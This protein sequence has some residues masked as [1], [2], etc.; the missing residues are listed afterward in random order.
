MRI[1][2][3]LLTGTLAAV[4]VAALAPSAGAD[5]GGGANT[6]AVTINDSGPASPSPSTITLSD[7]SGVVT[8]VAVTLDSVS[9]TWPDDLEIVL[10]APSGETVMLLNDCGGGADID[11]IDLRFAS[12]GETPPDGSSLIETTYAPFSCA[13]SGSIVI[14]TPAGPYGADFSVFDGIDPNG[15]WDLYIYDDV[16][17][18]TGDLAGWSIEVETT[19][20][21]PV[22]S[23]GGYTATE[24]LPLSVSAGLGLASTTVDPDDLDVLTWSATQPANG[25]VVL[26]SSDGSFTYTPD[27]DFTGV[28]TFTYSA[29]D[30]VPGIIILPAADRFYVASGG[31]EPAAEDKTDDGQSTGAPAATVE[32]PRPAS[33]SGAVRAAESNTSTITITVQP[34]NDPPTAVDDTAETTSGTAV[35][36][37]AAANDTD[38][39]DDTLTV[40]GVSDGVNG[41]ATVTDGDVVYTPDDDFVGT[42]VLTYTVSDGNGGEDEGEITIEVS[43]EEVD[44]TTTTT[45]ATTPTTTAASPTGTLPRTGAN[46]GP[47]GTLATTAYLLLAA[48]FL[49]TV[50]GGMWA[51]TRYQ[52]RHLRDA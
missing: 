33:K 11:A 7:I 38:V 4:S 49:L 45:T 21:A 1:G 34:V 47:T 28:D 9:H 17:A 48:G 35:T 10:E 3:I 40:T 46:G 44:D 14:P 5:A 36:V 27:P 42:E 15:A 13:F 41:T 39:E 32:I 16:G 12:G 26:D 25:T 43:A 18:D 51:R 37:D 31:A 19:N 8:D 23:D 29:D 24:D 6:G 20:T 2:R 30:G 52:P 50:A 22:T